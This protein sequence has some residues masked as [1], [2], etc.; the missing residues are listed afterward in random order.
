MNLGAAE[1]LAHTTGEYVMR[2]DHDNLFLADTVERR[3][4]WM[5]AHP[6]VDMA[7]SDG[8]VIGEDGAKIGTFGTQPWSFDRLLQSNFID[9]NAAVV[10]GALYRELSFDP[11]AWVEDWDCWLRLA[12]N[13]NVALMPGSTFQYRKHPWQMTR[14]RTPETATSEAQTREKIKRVLEER[15]AAGNAGA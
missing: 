5:E 15:R 14:E 3:V 13:H 8:D 1:A 12:M 9:S 10:K 7:Y 6:D 2:L 4:K 11:S